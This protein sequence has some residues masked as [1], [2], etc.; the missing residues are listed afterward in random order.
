MKKT[1]SIILVFVGVFVCGGVVG[2]ALSANQY[3]RFVE[4]RGANRSAFLQLRDV[5]EK[6][7]LTPEQKKKSGVIFERSMKERQAM[8][9]QMQA[10]N[11]RLIEDLNEVLTPEQRIKYKEL[12]A[13]QRTKE[14]QWQRWVREQRDRRSGNPPL[15]PDGKALPLPAFL[16]RRER[17]RSSGGPSKSE[18]S[19]PPAPRPAEPG[20]SP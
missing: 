16:E 5:G 9:K 18:E 4:D 13:Q 20:P 8:H 10:I 11:E 2:G 19:A 1:I 15:G 17:E 7:A 3:R 14:R 12:Q 6:L